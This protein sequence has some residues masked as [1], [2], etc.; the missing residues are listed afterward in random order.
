[1]I[2]YL[3]SYLL[4]RLLTLPLALLPYSLIHT[5]GKPLGSLLYHFYPKPRKRALSNLALITKPALSTKKIRSVAKQSI[6][7]LIITCM[8]Y[9][10]LS[11]TK[12]LG[13]LVTCS[14][15]DVPRAALE[16][17]KGAIFFCGHQA[18]WEL[19]FLDSTSRFKGVAIGRPVKNPYL[20]KWIIRIREKMG[21]KMI[22]P[23][24]ALKESLRAIKQG[25]FI[26]IVGDQG[27]PDSGFSSPF[28]GRSAWT[29]PLPALLAYRTGRP[30]F[31]CTLKRENG[32]YITHY[33]DPIWPNKENPM[34]EEICTVMEKTLACLQK[35]IE[36]HLD[37]WLWTHNRWKQQLPNIL[38]KQFRHETI[39]IL[40]PENDDSF[41]YIHTLLPT[42]RKLYPTEFI[43]LFIPAKFKSH[44]LP[45]FETHFYNSTND[46]FKHEH[47]HKLVFNFTHDPRLNSHFLSSAAF[48][49]YNIKDLH[50]LAQT[51]EPIFLEK[52]LRR[53]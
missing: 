38:K 29:S 49:V 33:S 44:S 22:P 51:E 32:K 7:N 50:T 9:P 28:F 35:S 14:N 6:Q 3:F 43:T 48:G 25:K 19:L 34:E 13:K 17:G 8:E 42:F 2:F 30:I 31:V 40:L 37:Q 27:M 1:M 10:K 47:F 24:A 20:Y 15:P 52:A 36:E 4:L 23:K 26:G 46:I 21:G 11:F 39:A 5:I 12:D 18:N 41:N 45:D 53:Q 16:N